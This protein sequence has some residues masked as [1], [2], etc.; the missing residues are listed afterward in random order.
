M[1]SLQLSLKTVTGS[2]IY[3][4]LLKEFKDVTRPEGFPPKIKH[5]TRH[6]I[7]TT[8]R[9]LVVCRPRRLAPECLTIAKN[10]FRKM[11]KSGIIGPSKST[12]FIYNTKEG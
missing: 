9:P 10:E 1:H 3:H 8:S 4:K 12:S 11:L 2:T 6:Y 7:E 5:T